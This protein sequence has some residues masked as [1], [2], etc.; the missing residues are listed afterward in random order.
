MRMPFRRS[1]RLVLP[2]LLFLIGA[3]AVAAQPGPDSL[4]SQA[5]VSLLT[6]LPGDAIYSL[7]GHSAIR[8]QDPAYGIDRTYN[9]GTFDFGDPLTF[10]PTFAYGRLDYF[11]SVKSFAREVRFY[12][13]VERRP[14]LEQELTL[15][16]DQRQQVYDFLRT[17][18]L[19][20]NRYYRYDFFFDN[21]STRLRDVMEAALGEEVRFAATPDPDASFRRLLDPYLVE[22][23]FLDLGMDLLLGTPADRDASARE[24]AYLPMYLKEAFDHASVRSDGA[25]QPLVARTDTV[26]WS[27]AAATPVPSL[28]WPQ[29]IGWALLAFGLVLSV[30]NLRRPPD[31]PRRHWFDAFLFGGVGVTGLLIAFLWG[32]SEHVVTKGNVDLIWAWPTHLVAAP[33]L[34]RRFRPDWLRWYLG[35]AAV[36]SGL[37]VITWTLWPY[38][39]P[40][41][42]P[43]MLLLLVRGGTYAV[44]LRGST[45]PAG[46]DE[47]EKKET[48]AG[49]A[50]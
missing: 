46:R 36:V 13:Q 18:A 11:L 28:P 47:D 4:S 25:W 16:P 9:Y 37:M 14:I 26:V 50:L 22:D 49:P 35:A 39:H 1:L 24:A 34:L 38:L 30:R 32:L 10:V 17:N 12:W 48:V 40:A 8:I 3:R 43:I 19:P 33:L 6:V 7:F 20:E 42:F 31:A 21:C 27:E 29:F 15:T 45:G 2:V 44:P 5:R 41:V 23:P